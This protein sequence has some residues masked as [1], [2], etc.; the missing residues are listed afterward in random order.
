MCEELTEVRYGA[1]SSTLFTIALNMA[2][3]RTAEKGNIVY[4]FKQICAYADDIVLVTR[5]IQ[6]GGMSYSRHWKLKA[7]KWTK[8]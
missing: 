8:N 5:N 3:E 2:P 4:K 6:G 1:M 7:E